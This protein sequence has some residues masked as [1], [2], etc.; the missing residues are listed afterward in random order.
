MFSIVVD[1]VHTSITVAPIILEDVEFTLEDVLSILHNI[2]VT[3]PTGLA[4]PMFS[5]FQRSLNEGEF[6]NEWLNAIIFPICTKGEE[7]ILSKCRPISFTSLGFSVFERILTNKIIDHLESNNLLSKHHHSLHSN[8]SCLTDNLDAFEENYPVDVIC[9]AWTNAFESIPHNHLI[10]K[11]KAYG[12]SGKVL[13]WIEGYLKNQTQTVKM[14]DV[15]S[16]PLLIPSGVS[17]VSILGRILFLIYIDDLFE[18][19]QSG[20]KIL[21]DYCTL[22]RSIKSPSDRDILQQ[23]L[24]KVQKWCSKWLIQ[25][26]ESK[27]KVKHIGGSNPKYDYYMN[28]WRLE[29]SEKEKNWI[30]FVPPDCRSS[31]HNKIAG[32]P[33]YERNN[34]VADKTNFSNLCKIYDHVF[35]Q[36]TR[37]PILKTDPNMNLMVTDLVSFGDLEDAIRVSKE[38]IPLGGTIIGTIH[39]VRH[40]HPGVYRCTQ[41]IPFEDHEPVFIY[42][43]ESIDPAK[44]I[45]QSYLMMTDF[46]ENNNDLSNYIGRYEWTHESSWGVASSEESEDDEYDKERLNKW[47]KKK[48]LGKDKELYKKRK[49]Y[50]YFASYENA[51]CLKECVKSE[52]IEYS[53]ISSSHYT[54]VSPQLNRPIAMAAEIVCSIESWKLGKA[55]QDISSQKYFA[56]MINSY[57]RFMD[58]IDQFSYG[59]KDPFSRLSKRYPDVQFTSVEETELKFNMTD[60]KF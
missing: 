48:R 47:L 38:K 36:D 7:T 14:D 37:Y 46:N 26:Y 56:L 53:N 40:F 60:F 6:P 39:T 43:H 57:A 21:A 27:C 10:A 16:D 34:D 50:M 12:I 32:K 33:I 17:R 54:V 11:L 2:K 35:S 41:V 28:K 52:C 44:I 18:G 4:K 55:F 24:L 20:G 3:S 8:Q 15:L 30:S 1:K 19:I 23:D 13:K 31:A 58:D 9:L 42:H 45:R 49:S 5:M 25:F 22:F 29:K 59:I 51:S